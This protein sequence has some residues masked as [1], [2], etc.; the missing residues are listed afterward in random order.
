MESSGRQR[1][2]LAI[3]RCLRRLL[4]Q[5]DKAL[6]QA[7]QEGRNRVC[8]VE[9]VPLRETD[10]PDRPGLGARALAAG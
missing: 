9:V 7:K 5:A 2:A 6:Y 8:S 3:R 1:H 10:S 4:G